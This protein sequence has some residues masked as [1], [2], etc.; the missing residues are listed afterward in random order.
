M[1]ALRDIGG[2]YAVQ[3]DTGVDAVGLAVVY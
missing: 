1:Q 3:C 2:A